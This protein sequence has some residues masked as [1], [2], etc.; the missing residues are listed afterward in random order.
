MPSS[1]NAS[2]T[3]GLVNTADTSGVLQLQTAGT[4][5]I[6]IDA[7]QA[8]SFTNSPTVT[9]GTAN[10]VAY[11]NGSKVLTTG[12]AL[13]FDGSNLGLGV[14]PSAWAASSAAF[15][16]S[17]GSIWRFGTGNIYLGQNYYYNGTNRIFVNNGYASEYN[18]NG[19]SHNWYSSNNGTAG[20]T[21]SQTQVL[22]VGIS[23]TLFLQGASASVS[24]TGITFPATQSASTDANTLD[25]YEE[26][27]WT[28]TATGSGTPGTYTVSVSSATYTK[29]GRLV[30]A[31]FSIGFSAASG[32]TGTFVIGGLPFN[33]T[34][35]AVII[36]SANAAS[37][38]TTAASSNGIIIGNLSGSSDTRLFFALVIDNAANEE[39]ACGAVSTATTLAVN[40]SYQV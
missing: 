24:G 30:N 19:S 34:S 28:P 5:A 32:G 20:G 15:Q 11:L 4:T 6:S 36:G 27:T 31:R 8:V 23:S 29:I 21:V 37:L 14:T 22:G 25:D 18:Q 3:A 38:N 2:T 1:I 16:N 40:F 7:S 10:G 17:A 35:L 12:T 39:I 13:V 33:Y 26:G 9:G